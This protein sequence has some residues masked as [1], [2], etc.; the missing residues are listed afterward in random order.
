MSAPVPL[1]DA[2]R[3]AVHT[4]D[5]ERL[6]HEFSFDALLQMHDPGH[7]PPR[8]RGP[9]GK[10]AHLRCRRCP[11]VWVV[12]EEPGEGYEDAVARLIAKFRDPNDAKPKP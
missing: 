12:I 1:T 5:C 9:E 11:K 3:N 8:V 7:A 4:E 10:L 2:I 6:G